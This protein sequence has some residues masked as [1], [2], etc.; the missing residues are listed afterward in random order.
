MLPV[1]GKVLAITGNEEGGD[2]GI[3]FDHGG[4]IPAVIR[5]RKCG[6]VSERVGSQEAA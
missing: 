1:V 5:C 3:V 4:I 2:C 6:R